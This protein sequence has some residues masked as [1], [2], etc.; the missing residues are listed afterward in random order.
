ME[1]I[2]DVILTDYE[3][4][5]SNKEKTTFIN[6]IKERLSDSGYDEEADITVE[7]SGYGIFKTR[8]IIVGNPDTAEVFITAHYDTCAVLPFPNVMAPTNPLLFIT[9]QVI[10]SLLLIFVAELCAVPVGFITRDPVIT[11]R[12]FLCALILMLWHMMFGYRNK[13]TANDNT[14]GVITITKILEETPAEKRDKICAI[15]FDNE[16]KGLLG[17]MD[18]VK[19][20]R[21]SVQNKLVLNFDCVG[22]GNHVA[23]FAKRKAMKDKKYA[24]LVEVLDNTAK[25][26]SIYSLNKKVLPM[27]FPSDNMNFNRGIGF[28]GLKKSFIGLY[29]GRIH[30]PLD[31][32]CSKNNIEF[33]V[34]SILEFVNKIE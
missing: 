27:M 15:Y 11:Y 33:L 14:S 6:Y 18:F 3:V 21:K 8:N 20:H 9:F 13:H 12:V 23:S 24:L 28:C 7:G 25:E 5:K 26:F 19:K 2:K 10:I 1:N 32:K 30:T 29:T 31:T 17:S 4:R 16:E 34:N 22:D